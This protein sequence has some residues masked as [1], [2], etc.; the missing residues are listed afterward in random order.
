MQGYNLKTSK[1]DNTGKTPLGLP[2]YGMTKNILPMGR[3]L[4]RIF[5]FS[6]EENNKIFYNKNCSTI[7]NSFDIFIDFSWREE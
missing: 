4:N 1:R 2:I 6:H 5:T 3:I 7:L